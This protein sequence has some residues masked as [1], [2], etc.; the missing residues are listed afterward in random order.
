[1]SDN[2]GTNAVQSTSFDIDDSLGDIDS[3]LNE[4][5]LIVDESVPA[6]A[7]DEATTYE[8]IEGGPDTQG[9]G[10][11]VDSVGFTY[12]WKRTKKATTWTWSENVQSL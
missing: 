3:Q 1:M 2:N 8:L 6:V 5:S 4:T 12:A 10:L 9:R 11:V 7:D